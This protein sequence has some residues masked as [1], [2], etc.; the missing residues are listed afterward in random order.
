MTRLEK[1]AEGTAKELEQMLNSTD[2]CKNENNC[3]HKLGDDECI[4]CIE[5][6]LKEEVKE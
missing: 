2:F 4:E 1:I 5:K 3:T 6:W